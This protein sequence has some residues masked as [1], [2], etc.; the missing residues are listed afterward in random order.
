MQVRALGLDGVYE[1]I[2]A[3]FG[4]ARGFFSETWKRSTLA[5]HGIEADRVQVDDLVPVPRVLQSGVEPF[6]DRVA[7]GARIVVGV[8]GENLH[9]R[10]RGGLG[11]DATGPPGTGWR[12]PCSIRPTGSD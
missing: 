9:A 6:K 10:S 12:G 4:D 7:E 1:I 11:W 5:E 8:D 2:P 3:R